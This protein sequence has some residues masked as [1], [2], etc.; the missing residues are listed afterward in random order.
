MMKTY[1]TKIKRQSTYKY[2][3]P[4]FNCQYT[5]FKIIL[6]PT[7][8]FCIN[9]LCT[10][11]KFKNAVIKTDPQH[12]TK[13]SKLIDLVNFNDKNRINSCNFNDTILKF[14]RNSTI[15]FRMCLY[16]HG[17]MFPESHGFVAL[18]VARSNN[19]VSLH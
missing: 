1:R 3:Y 7:I 9:G 8:D 2:I 10:C 17:N 16:V 11:G 12:H 13:L 4:V 19:F 15:H 5:L 6:L 18:P 14:L